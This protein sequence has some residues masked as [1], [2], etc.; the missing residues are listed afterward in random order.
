MGVNITILYLFNYTF[1]F[2]IS[3]TGQTR[4]RIFTF[5]GSNE[6]DSRKDVPRGG[7]VFFANL[8]INLLACY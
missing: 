4:Q 7:F 8:S 6:T 5:D 2:M 3:P 1:L